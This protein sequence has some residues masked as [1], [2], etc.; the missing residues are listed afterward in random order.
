VVPIDITGHKFG[1]LT[2]VR[3]VGSDTF[4]KRVWEFSCACG[5]TTVLAG[6]L[7]RAGKV[8]SCGCLRS[9][10][11]VENGRKSIGPGVK[12]G[13]AGTA[14]YAVW[15]TM[16]QRCNNP[17]SA[18]YALYGGRGIK[19]CALWDSFDKFQSDMGPRPPGHTIERINNDG[20]YSP[21]N[22][23]WATLKEQANNRRARGTATQGTTQWLST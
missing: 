4:G 22:C 9:E 10:R 17:R 23:R 7:A 18:D 2:A 15:K 13:R 14:V 1:R 3:C 5:K 19:V 11:A 21:E 6:S 16:R 20:D 12:H 8:K